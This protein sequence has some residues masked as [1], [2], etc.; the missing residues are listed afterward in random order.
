[1]NH[2]AQDS[3]IMTRSNLASSLTRPVAGQAG[4]VSGRL[5]ETVDL[6]T[7]E[8][9]RV[10]RICFVRLTFLN[11]DSQPNLDDENDGQAACRVGGDQLVLT[12]STSSSSYWVPLL[13]YAVTPV[14]GGQIQRGRRGTTYPG[15]R[16]LKVAARVVFYCWW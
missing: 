12:L 11:V 3:A 8:T 15:T 13:W 14:Y 7:P 16:K 5:R 9:E 2:L 1:M 6:H 4:V 10:H